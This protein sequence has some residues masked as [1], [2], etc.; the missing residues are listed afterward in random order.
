MSNKKNK[1]PST[2]T[3]PS[4][5]VSSKNK[6]KAKD[7]GPYLP[8]VLLSFVTIAAVIAAVYY[9]PGTKAPSITSDSTATPI[10]VDIADSANDHVAK[11]LETLTNGVQAVVPR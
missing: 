1:P 9:R 4:S 6:S 2:T 3:E 11:E 10:R 8:R 5:S 7:E